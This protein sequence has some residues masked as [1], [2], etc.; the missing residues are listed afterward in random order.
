[1]ER[2]N[3]PG[4]HAPNAC[5]T[6]DRE[7][8]M[9]ILSKDTD[10]THLPRG[11]LWDMDGTLLDS[12][13]YHW[14]SW[15]DA[16][17]DEGCYITYN[18]FAA[19]FGQRNDTILQGYFGPDISAQEIDRISWNK[20][21]LYRDLVRTRGIQLLPGVQHWLT[22][23]N[24]RGWHQAVASS[25]PRLNIEV[26]IDV[27][28]LGHFFQAISS[29]DDVAQGKPA[30][31]IFLTAAERLGVPTARCIVVEDA[32]H[33]VEAGRRAGMRTIGVRTTHS[34]L[35]ADLVV[36]ALDELPDNAFD[37]LIL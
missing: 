12:A 29:A 20:E 3:K 10:M 30:P 37:Q 33:G 34:D 36:A 21:E 35:E 17:A 11:V 26:I 14:L 2:V 7:Y 4:C 1:M 27:L 32:P 6:T 23:L 8:T 15:R 28:Q 13:H 24:A 9:I 31:D 22:Y 18:Q 25:A 19:T 5:G 16:L